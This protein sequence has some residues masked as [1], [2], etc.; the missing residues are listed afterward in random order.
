MVCDKSK[1]FQPMW[2]WFQ[3]IVLLDAILHLQ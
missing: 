3:D 2:V 1:Q